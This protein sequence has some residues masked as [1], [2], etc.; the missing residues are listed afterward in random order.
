MSLQSTKTAQAMPLSTSLLL[1]SALIMMGMG[2]TVVFAILPMLGR[3]L[4]VDKLVIDLPALGIFFEPKEMA[5]TAL[6]ACTSLAFFIGAAYWGRLSDQWGRKPIIM[7][8]LLG[9]ILGTFLFNGV[10][11]LGL[12]GVLA[13]FIMYWLFVGVRTLLVLVMSATVPSVTAYM[14]DVVPSEQR[15]AYLSKLTAATQIGTLSGPA[16]VSFVTF[17]FLAPLYVH[18]TVTLLVAIAI[19]LWL[20][21]TQKRLKEVSSIPKLSFFDPR[22]RQFLMIGLVAFTVQTMVQMSLGFYFEDQFGLSRADAAMKLSIALLVC[23]V[24]MLLAQFLVVVRWKGAPVGLVKWGVPMVSLGCAIVA[25]SGSVIILMA[26]MMVFGFG[27]GMVI[28]GFTVAATH[29]V[30]SDEQGALAGLSASATAL[31]FV[32]GPLLSGYLY[33]FSP[34]LNFWLGVVS[35]TALWL[36]ALSIRMPR[37]SR[38]QPSVTASAE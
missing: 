4:E 5:I 8:G 36:F 16:L 2:Q 3:E 9:Y 29:T 21:V 17:G 23:S 27:M 7:I 38:V 15:T 14:V 37:K 18:A 1:Y 10:A 33:H 19:W 31:G 13:G 34:S 20:P 35:L 11:Q 28:P 24:A 6:T 12:S 22:Y 30:T 32:F 25:A 26:G